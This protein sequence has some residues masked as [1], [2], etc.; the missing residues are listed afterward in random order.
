MFS[1]TYESTDAISAAAALPLPKG[2]YIGQKFGNLTVKGRAAN[3][4][5]GRV[6]LICECDCPKRTVRAVRLSDLRSGHTRGCT[7]LR[8]RSRYGHARY[9]LCNMGTFTVI[10][11]VHE[12]VAK[13]RTPWAVCCHRCRGIFFTTT[14]QI[15]AG[16]VRCGCLHGTFNTWRNVIQ[17]CLNPRNPAFA[18]YGGRGIAVSQSWR[19]FEG[20][21]AEMGIRPEG[22]TLDRSDVNGPYTR[23]NCRWATP[24]EQAGNRRR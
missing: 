5:S 18:G 12:G 11:K 22:K 6:R 10:A 8:G 17:R 23:A 19:T 9:M 21:L 3:D 1:T 16:K 14:Q 4:A 13:A 2:I 20:F 24:K 7:C 15:L